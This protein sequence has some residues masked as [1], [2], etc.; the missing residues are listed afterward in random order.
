MINPETKQEDLEGGKEVPPNEVLQQ[1]QPVVDREGFEQRKAESEAQDRK[2]LEVLLEKI[3]QQEGQQVFEQNSL[4]QRQEKIKQYQ[5]K[6]LPEYLRKSNSVISRTLK[7]ILIGSWGECEKSG[8]ENIPEKGPFVVIGNHF[9]GGDA[10]AIMDTFQGSNLHFGIAKRMWWDAS[11]INK[12][13]LKKLGMILVEESLAN[14]SE[15]EKEE[16]LKRQGGHGKRVFRQIIDREKEGGTATNTEFVRQ[17]VALLSRGETLSLYPEGVWLNP[18]G[19]GKLARERKEMK[20]G[21]GGLELVAR[22]YKKLTGEDLPIVPT[23]YIEDAKSKQRKLII[24]KPLKLSQND[25]DFNDTDWVM[26]HV[27]EMLPEEQRGYYKDA[28]E[29]I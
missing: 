19:A 5:E 24:G 26:A 20:Q 9:G 21:Y 7:R 15:D 25:S 16:A 4:D 1:E 10:E 27:A 2:E 28:V 18:E 6:Y 13:V 3:R 23:A 14:L 12:W 8:I 22:Q 29:K 17:S 11:P